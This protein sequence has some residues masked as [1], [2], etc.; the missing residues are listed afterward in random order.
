METIRQATIA[1][2]PALLPLMEAFNDVE[3]IPWRPEV[4]SEAAARLLRDG[5]LG[6]VVVAERTPK[7]LSG[8]AIATFGYDLEFAGRDAFI[9]ELYVD[10][11][12]RGHGLGTSLLTTTMDALK[13]L[14]VGAVHLMVRPQN[15]AAR[16]LYARLG[17]SEVPRLMMTKNFEEKRAG[18]CAKAGATCGTDG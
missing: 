3:G 9:T 17:F 2:L 5:S 13:G 10:R 1:D 6:T 14:D 12:S 7:H 8:Y 4:M 16:R 18:A 15:G 11:E